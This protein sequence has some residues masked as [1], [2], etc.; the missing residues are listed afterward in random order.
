MKLNSFTNFF[1]FLPQKHQPDFFL[2]P[3]PP[4]GE[5]SDYDNAR[6]FEGK[7]NRGGLSVLPRQDF[8]RD[9]G[10][11]FKFFFFIPNQLYYHLSSSDN[12][13]S[14]TEILALIRPPDGASL[15]LIPP[16]AESSSSFISCSRQTFWSSPWPL[17]EKSARSK[18]PGTA[19]F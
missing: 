7:M 3:L 16:R 11:H 6:Y 1:F 17:L 12:A 18:P 10:A 9:A 4:P 19:F 2:P 15:S 5:P 8:S 14:P 13:E